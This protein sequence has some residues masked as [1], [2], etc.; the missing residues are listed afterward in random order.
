MPPGRSPQ[1]GGLQPHLPG[2][3]RVLVVKQGHPRQVL[4]STEAAGDGGRAD[5]H[6]VVGHEGLGPDTRP[7]AVA[8]PER[9]LGAAGAPERDE[10]AALADPDLHAGVRGPER[11][12]PRHQPE[13]GHGAGGGEPDEPR[14][15]GAGRPEDLGAPLDQ[16]ERGGERGRVARCLGSR[17]ETS[18]ASL[19]ER[20]AHPPLEQRH[21]LADR[22]VGHAELRGG[23]DGGSEAGTGL[24][25]PE[26][27]ERGQAPRGGVRR[28]HRGGE[29]RP[30]GVPVHCAEKRH[31]IASSP[32]RRHPPPPEP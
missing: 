21:L 14:Q 5:D 13:G 10:L 32:P 22:P 31:V 1:A 15:I 12:Q 9:E 2:E 19:E 6:R 20:R 16:I 3:A 18:S 28:A 23:G 17:H 26:G 11:R 29:W 8:E 25:R 24:E 30:R 7:G 4:R 27:V